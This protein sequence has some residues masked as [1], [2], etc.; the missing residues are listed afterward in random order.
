MA[1]AETEAMRVVNELKIG[2]DGDALQNDKGEEED[3]VDPWTVASSSAKG[4]D[5]DKLISK[6]IFFWKWLVYVCMYTFISDLYVSLVHYITVAYP[7]FVVLTK[8]SSRDK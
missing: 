2:L 8:T 3:V 4:V 5:Y 7:V 1:E 6:F